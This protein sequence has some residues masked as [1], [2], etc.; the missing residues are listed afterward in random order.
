[1]KARNIKITFSDAIELYN[2]GNERL[3]MLALNAF[4]EKELSNRFNRI[5]TLQDACM[6]LNLDTTDI[7]RKANDIAKVS[8]ASAAMFKLN[9]IRKA[10][11]L[12]YDLYLTKDHGDYGIYH[13][14][15]P[16]LVEDSTYFESDI[17]SGKM[18]I[19]GKIFSDGMP[20]NVLSGWAGR[21]AG[22][23]LGSFHYYDGVGHPEAD[24]GFLG[25]ATR[26]IA[27]HFGKYF[28]MLIIEAMYGD[29]PGF[30]IIEEKYHHL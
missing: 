19:I 8:K 25:C 26:E 14:H 22:N 21:Y 27:E 12:G 6:A 23:G 24:N 28:G 4:T 9:I 15:N 1:M 3:K 29:L 2:S 5:Q 16:F 17:D 7:I 11:N 10:L 13:P 20:Y 18:E 30:T